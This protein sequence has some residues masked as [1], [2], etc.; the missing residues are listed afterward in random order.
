MQKYAGREAHIIKGRCLLKNLSAPFMSDKVFGGQSVV[1]LPIEYIPMH[2]TMWSCNRVMNQFTS[3]VRWKLKSVK[4]TFVP[5]CGANQSGS[6]WMAFTSCIQDGG[7]DG[8]NETLQSAIMDLPGSTN[9][10]LGIPTGSGCSAKMPFIDAFDWGFTCR[11]GSDINEIYQGALVVALT[12]GKDLF[13]NAAGNV[14]LG[15]LILDYEIALAEPASVL[16]LLRP[17]VKGQY[18]QGQIPVGDSVRIFFDS[19]SCHVGDILAL[20]WYPPSGDDNVINSLAFTEGN[21]IG[22]AVKKPENGQTVYAKVMNQNNA[23]VKEA[24]IY[25]SLAAAQQAGQT[26]NLLTLPNTLKNT[27]NIPVD[28]TSWLTHSLNLAKVILPAVLDT[29]VTL[30]L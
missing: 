22:L 28:S 13:Y 18:S 17:R 26:T 20:P 7:P 19:A 29:A 30:L 4:V 12:G 10:S 23:A 11:A 16:S 9:C 14:Y 24:V 25:P 8:N 21:Q 27:G 5:Y 3:Y 15:Q 6:L 1:T 2:P